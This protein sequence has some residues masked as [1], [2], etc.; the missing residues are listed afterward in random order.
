[1]Q[2]FLFPSALVLFLM[3][4]QAAIAAPLEQYTTSTAAMQAFVTAL[5]NHDEAKLVALFGAHG[6][7]VIRSGDAVADRTAREKF[8][9]AYD[10][11]HEVDVEG[12]TATI[13]VGPDNWPFP[14]PLH[15]GTDGWRFDIAAG[16]EEILD[17]RVGANELAAQ[18]VMLAYVEA[19]EEYADRLHDGIKLHVYAQKLL[20]SP[21]KQDGLYWPAAPGQP[22]S[23]LGELVADARAAGYHPGESATPQPYHG[24]LY[25]IL[26]SQGPHAPGGAY[27][28]VVN[29]LMVGGFGLAAWPANWGNSGVLSFVVNQDGELYAK[30]LGPRTTELAPA[31][32]SFDPDS[33]WHKIGAPPPSPGASLE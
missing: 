5:R 9:A 26:K 3:T 25:K 13:M 18:Q 31:L 30:D 24:Y 2:S 4:T 16:E 6:V 1:M 14:V 33:S 23:P 11:R 22:L 32:T 8:L 21:G 10:T 28:Y 29:G 27:D 19:Q 20:S 17:R 12:T 7:D 15:H